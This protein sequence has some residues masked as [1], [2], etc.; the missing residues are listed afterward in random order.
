MPGSTAPSSASITDSVCPSAIEVIPFTA[1]AFSSLSSASSRRS[2][3]FLSAV[4][5][6]SRITFG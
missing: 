2:S 5:P 6:N 3:S 4:H 1:F